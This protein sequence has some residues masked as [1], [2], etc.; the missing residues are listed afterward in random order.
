MIKNRPAQLGRGRKF[1]EECSDN[2][3][4]PNP[5]SKKNSGIHSTSVNS[6]P[7][8][9]GLN[10]PHGSSRGSFV[11]AGDRLLSA[12]IV[13]RRPLCFKVW[14]RL[15]RA[16]TWLA[17]G[18]AARLNHQ[19]LQPMPILRHCTQ[20]TSDDVGRRGKLYRKMCI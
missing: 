20:A 17:Q 15:G 8:D 1:E 6:V 12:A 4:N 3:S 9:I 2:V 13:E 5:T 14:H 18:P 7:N 11:R 16:E 10:L 19:C